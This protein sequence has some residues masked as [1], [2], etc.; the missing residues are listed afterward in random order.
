MKNLKIGILVCGAAILVLLL[1]N[2]FI[3]SLKADALNT[4]LIL[5]GCGLP[6]AM[7]IM[8][9]TKPPFLQW[10]AIASLV[11]F[12]IL[13]VR[14]VGIWETLPHIGDAPTEYK[15]VIIATVVGL[16]LSILAVAKPEN[17]A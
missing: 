7:G 15:I 8:G 13:C 16:I 1:K 6:T 2:H 11:G 10:Q 9:L 4:I 17:K 12:G 14:P 5:V 3:D